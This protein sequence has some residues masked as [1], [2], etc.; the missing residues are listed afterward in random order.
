MKPIH[1]ETIMK[2]RL[3]VVLPILLLTLGALTLFS[4]QAPAGQSAQEKPGIDQSASGGDLPLNIR[5]TELIGR[6][7]QNREG[8]PIAEI[9]DLII[10]RQGRIKH[11]ILSI[12]G[13]LGLGDKLLAVDFDDLQF[14]NRWTY[15]KIRTEDGTREKIAWEMHP[16][17]IFDGSEDELIKKPEYIYPEKHPRGGSSGWG[18]YSYPAGPKDIEEVP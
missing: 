15:R 8:E 1:F 7:V 11:I 9:D 14:Q 3:T 2:Q 13:Y 18:V 5:A 10:D 6:S 4:P 17:V 12:G 16:Q